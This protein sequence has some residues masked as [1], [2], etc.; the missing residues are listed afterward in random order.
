MHTDLGVRVLPRAVVA[1]WEATGWERGPLG[2]P[3]A[4]AVPTAGGA[5]SVVAFQGGEVHVTASGG[6]ALRG[7]VLVGSGAQDRRS[8]RLGHGWMWKTPRSAT[9]AR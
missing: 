4:D 7:A 2:Y 3:V 5:G 9:V 1:A 8:D 6:H